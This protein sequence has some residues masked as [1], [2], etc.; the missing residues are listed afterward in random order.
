MPDC[1]LQPYFIQCSLFWTGKLEGSKWEKDCEVKTLTQPDT[2]S[3]CN[4]A[5]SCHVSLEKFSGHLFPVCSKNR[6]MRQLH[7]SLVES[8]L[9]VHFKG[10]VTNTT[11][12]CG[13]LHPP[14]T[15]RHCFLRMTPRQKSYFLYI[16]CRVKKATALFVRRAG[17]LSTYKR[18]F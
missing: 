6:L 7:Y 9:K 16:I 17:S 18:G 14:V 11:D 1:R 8:R 2:S 5:G 10:P 4:C 12:E 13:F 3:S 15:L